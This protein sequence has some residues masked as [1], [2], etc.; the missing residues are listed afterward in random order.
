M[1]ER[2]ILEYRDGSARALP[3]PLPCCAGDLAAALEAVDDGVALAWMYT[4]FLEKEHNGHRVFYTGL[5]GR[6]GRFYRV[7]KPFVDAFDRTDYHAAVWT[8]SASPERPD[9]TLALELHPLSYD[10]APQ[11]SCVLRTVGDLKR[12]LR[13]VE[14]DTTLLAP[15]RNFELKGALV[16]GEGVLLYLGQD[17]QGRD[18]LFMALD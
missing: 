11:G 10:G 12:L 15:S 3:S 1:A 14:P 5:W 4:G 2:A 13:T 7:K 8:F 16:D 18:Y 17:I 6:V 9:S